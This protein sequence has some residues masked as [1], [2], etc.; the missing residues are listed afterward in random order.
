MEECT[1]KNSKIF[2][3]AFL[4]FHFCSNPFPEVG[5]PVRFMKNRLEGQ[6]SFL[7]IN[8]NNFFLYF[9]SFPRLFQ[10]WLKCLREWLSSR[11]RAF[12]SWGE[13]VGDEGLSLKTPSSP[14]RPSRC[15]T[16]GSCRLGWPGRDPGWVCVTGEDRVLGPD[17]KMSKTAWKQL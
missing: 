2:L 15:F 14:P 17:R 16:K 11:V 4:S 5:Q 6:I 12:T 9:P 8:H 3:K 13:L 1:K 10:L 7:I